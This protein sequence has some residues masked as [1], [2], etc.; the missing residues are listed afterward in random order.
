PS[1]QELASKLVD[2]FALWSGV[3]GL[4][5]VPVVDAA[6]VAGLQ[7]QMVRRISQIYDVNFSE[8]IG[9][10]LIA[11][12]AGAMVPATSSIGAASLLKAVPIVGTIAS[13]FVMPVLAS[14]AT[15]AIGK[16]FIQHFETGGTLLDFNPPDYREFLRSQKELWDIR[17]KRLRTPAAPAAAATPETEPTATQ[18]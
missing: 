16:A 10:G 17:R 12:L 1:R 3:A 7:L 18:P 13:G 6:T 15:F 14:G 8:N 4:I 5:P 9:K 2:R 11:A